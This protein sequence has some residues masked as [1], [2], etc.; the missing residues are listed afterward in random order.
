MV[1]KNYEISKMLSEE[2]RV[3]YVA[4]TRAKEKIII[5]GY[6]SSLNKQI[7]KI[8]SKIGNEKLIS[9]LYLNT[10]KSYLDIIMPCLLRHK[11]CDNL[12]DYS[13]V[14]IKVFDSD[15]LINTNIINVD[16]ENSIS[17]FNKTKK[18]IDNK[19]LMKKIIDKF[20]IL[21]DEEVI[22]KFRE[23]MAFIREEKFVSSLN[24]KVKIIGISDEGHLIIEDDGEIKNV[25]VG[26]ILVNNN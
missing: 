21:K 16:V 8:A 2:L 7:S 19:E 24:K 26:E 6:T 5:T 4:L 18:S 20:F 3:L 22:N 1:Y 17:F 25:F 9:N 14:D 11:S 13:M 15:S 12:R 10:T 23:N